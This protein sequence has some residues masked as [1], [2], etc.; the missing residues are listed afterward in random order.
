[1]EIPGGNEP[2]A[3]QAMQEAQMNPEDLGAKQ[4]KFIDTVFAQDELGTKGT[5]DKFLTGD[6]SHLLQGMGIQMKIEK[7]PLE[8]G[9]A[10]VVESCGDTHF[11]RETDIA[12]NGDGEVQSIR[13]TADP[14]AKVPDYELE[15]AREGS[16]DFA[17]TG[18]LTN[19][20]DNITMSRTFRGVIHKRCGDTRVSD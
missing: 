8:G 2:I 16:G 13:F 11:Q 1:M 19:A 9:L 15:V 14:K 17:V 3:V 4:R 7:T 6:F 18:R 20:D 5:K 10:R 12:D